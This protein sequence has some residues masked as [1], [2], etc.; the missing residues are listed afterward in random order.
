MKTNYKA[1][2]TGEIRRFNARLTSNPY[3]RF[4]FSALLLMVLTII[5]ASIFI[6]GTARASNDIE[7]VELK[8]M[9]TLQVVS[10]LSDTSVNSLSVNSMPNSCVVATGNT[11]I[12]RAY[13]DVI[14]TAEVQEYVNKYIEKYGN[15]IDAEL[16]YSLIYTESRFNPKAENEISYCS[17]IMQLAPK[18]FTGEI[19]RFGYD[20][21]FDLEGNIEIGIWYLSNLVEEHNGDLKYALTCYHCGDTGAY[22]YYLA[23]NDYDAYAYEVYGRYENMTGENTDK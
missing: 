10:A 18:Y 17:G 4:G 1:I 11:Y 3:G 2:R 7:V 23:H 14:L 6:S 19:E 12:D 16:V 22:C 5:F 20:S 9:P 15:R 8:A 21:I 13:L